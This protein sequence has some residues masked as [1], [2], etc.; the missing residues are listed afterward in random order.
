LLGFY[1]LAVVIVAHNEE[2]GI[3]PKLYQVI[4]SLDKQYSTVVDGI[5]TDTTLEVV[6]DW[7]RV[8]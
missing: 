1:P 8:V 5:G 3:S 7:R 2:N 4:D 6:K